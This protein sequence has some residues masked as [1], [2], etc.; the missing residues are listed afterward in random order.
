MFTLEALKIVVVRVFEVESITVSDAIS[1]RK[2]N[3]S[4]PQIHN[5]A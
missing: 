5:E 3:I 1:Y 4:N 2:H